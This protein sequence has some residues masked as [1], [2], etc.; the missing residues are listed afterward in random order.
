MRSI[1]ASIIILY[2]LGVNVGAMVHEGY[3]QQGQTEDDM[4]VPGAIIVSFAPQIETESIKS[5]NGRISTG[6]LELDNILLRNNVRNIEKLFATAKPSLTAEAAGGSYPL[7]ADDS[8][9]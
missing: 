5:T 8:R 2:F 7:G 3:D 1:I 4:R 6:S 9:A